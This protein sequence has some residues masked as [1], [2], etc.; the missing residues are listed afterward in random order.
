M[1]EHKM[2]PVASPDIGPLEIQYVNEAVSS[3]WV[4]SMGPFI[5]RFEA[6]FSAFCETPHAIALSNGTDA[7]YLA[8]EAVGVGRGDEVILPAL[9]FAAVAAVVKQLGAQPVL[10][11]IDAEHWCIDPA[12]VERAITK[13]TKA[14]VA[15]HSY[16]HPADM[17]AL[18]A[19]GELAGVP[20]IEDAAEAHGARCR[21]ALVGGIGRIGAFSFYGNKILTTGEGGAVTTHD[22]ELAAK[23]RFLKDHAMSPQRRYFHTEVGHNFRMTNLQAALGCAQ[24]ERREEL[25]AARRAVLDAYLEAWGEDPRLSFNPKASWAEPVVWMVCAMIPKE[26]QQDREALLTALRSAGIDTRPFFIPIAEMPPYQDCRVVG[27]E[28]EG[29]PVAESVSQRAF[30]LPSGH[31]LSTE[32]I[33][34]IV[35]TLKEELR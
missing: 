11:D 29:T 19:I 21:G 32:Q 4:S 25:F 31:G 17:Q 28:G 22:A 15:V 26:S 34:N 1:S 14:I 30:N 13:K 9:T 18:L 23:M 5:D 27:A 8:L 3:G 24:L 16:G 10:A 20:V 33:K 6:G 35:K 7:V 12:A 2:I